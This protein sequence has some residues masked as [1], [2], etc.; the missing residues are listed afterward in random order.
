MLIEEDSNERMP[1][2]AEPLPQ[3]EIGLTERWIAQGA[4]NDGGAEDWPLAELARK[5]LLRPAP[6]KYP[7]PV[8]ITALGFRADGTQLAVSG[9][10]EV[11]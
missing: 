2:K 8:P 3:G 6:E 10:Y 7:R 11:T 5:A 4:T 1:Q 9:Y